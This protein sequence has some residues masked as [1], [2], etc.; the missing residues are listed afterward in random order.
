MRGGQE[1]KQKLAAFLL[2]V[3]VN[4][5]GTK[6][7]AVSFTYITG[8]GAP[9]ADTTYASG[10]N[11]S[12]QITGYLYD[13][14]GHAFVDSNGAFTD[15]NVQGAS[16]TYAYGINDSGQIT[17]YYYDSTGE[18]S[19]IATPVPAPDSLALL[20]FGCVI[21][22]LPLVLRRRMI[23]SVTRSGN[24]PRDFYN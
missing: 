23:P 16:F 5:S 8:I 21:G 10:I 4:L 24:R 9:G 20:S 6:A 19:F 11:D 3:V 15:I 17:G 7:S 18:F 2:I 14:A 1:L 12:G 22:L 13:S